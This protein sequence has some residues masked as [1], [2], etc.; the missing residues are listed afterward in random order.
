[1]PPFA[2]LAAQTP[3]ESL[4]PGV[5]GT[6]DC[7]VCLQP[8]QKDFNNPRGTVHITTGNGGPPGKDNFKEH[9]PGA[10]CGSIPA[11]RKQTT[12][13]GYG[14]VVVHNSSVLEFTQFQNA[15]QSVFDHFVVVQEKHGPFSGQ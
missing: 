4:F 10:D 14:R 8:L 2:T 15:D 6:E 9:C 3:D 1:M 12:D 5:R 13:Y 7:K 11:T